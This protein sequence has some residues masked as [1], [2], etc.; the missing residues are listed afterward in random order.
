MCADM[1]VLTC[2][3]RQGHARV[4]RRVHRQMDRCVHRHFVPNT[5]MH[6]SHHTVRCQI[7]KC[8][9]ASI[10]MCIQTRVRR[11]VQT[12]SHTCVRACG[13]TCGRTCGWSCGRAMRMDTRTATC[14]TALGAAHVWCQILKC[15]IAI[16]QYCAKY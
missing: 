10:G 6:Y 5:K 15:I 2:V 9:G 14:H 11:R 7:L 4:Y 8:I 1:W 13:R 3:C 16:T 12:C